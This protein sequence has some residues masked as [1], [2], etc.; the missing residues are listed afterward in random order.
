MNKK[1]VG[2]KFFLLD[3]LN[4]NIHVPAEVE[5]TGFENKRRQKLHELTSCF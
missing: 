2:E 3:S 5:N 4:E 1:L